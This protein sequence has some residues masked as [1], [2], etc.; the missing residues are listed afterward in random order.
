MLCIPEVPNRKTNVLLT[1]ECSTD[2][3]K[4]FSMYVYFGAF[5]TAVS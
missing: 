2:K 3:E 5:H 4:E 1:A